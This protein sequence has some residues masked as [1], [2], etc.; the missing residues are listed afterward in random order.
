MEKNSSD[1]ILKTYSEKHTQMFATIKDVDSDEEKE[2]GSGDGEEFKEN[3]DKSVESTK[4]KEKKSNK[5]SFANELI[6]RG[7]KSL[8]KIAGKNSN[9]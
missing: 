9:S 3:L 6:M 1:R 7:E 5:Y 8:L 4:A 2:S